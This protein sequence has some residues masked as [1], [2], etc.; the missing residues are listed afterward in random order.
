MSTA[1]A[2]YET[3]EELLQKH[4]DLLAEAASAAAQPGNNEEDVRVAAAGRL[5]AFIV[6]A[7]L[8]IKARHEYGLAGRRIDSKY[9]GV[10]IEY[11]NSNSSADRI[12]PAITAG[13]TQRLVRQI[14]GRFSDFESREGVPKDRIFAAGIDGRFILFVR[15]RNDKFEHDGPFEL[16]AATAERLLR[17]IVSLGANGEAF[18][19]V[20]LVR[21]FGSESK[22]A[23]AGIAALYEAVLSTTDA[24]AQMLF[25]EWKLLF[26]EV[27][28]YDVSGQ[29]KKVRKLADHYGITNARPAELL[30]AVH[31]YYSIFMKFMAAQIATGFESLATSIVRKC[32]QAPSMKALKREM[33]SLENGSLWAQLGVKNFLE[34][35]LFAWYLAAWDSSVS[36]V[37]AELATGL[38]RYD[39][40]TLSVDPENSR[41]LLKM[42]YEHL[43]PRS[44][45][46]DLGE[47]YT[48]DWLAEVV[49]DRVGY[50]GNPAMRV[51]DPACGSGT[52]L[53]AVLKRIRKWYADHRE[54]CGY[55]DRELISKILSNVIGFDLNPLAVMASKVNVLIAVR[56]LLKAAGEIEIPVYLCD[57]IVLPEDAGVSLFGTSWRIRTSVGIFSVPQ[58][59][60][61]E[62]RVLAKYAEI[63]EESVKG[64]YDATDFIERCESEGVPVTSQVEHLKLFAKCQK[65][66]SENKNGIWARIIKNAFAPLFL[67]P[68]DF[69]V[70]NPP[71]VNWEHMPDDYRENLKKT[72]E[73]YGLFTLSGTDARLGGGKKDL[74]MLFVYACVDR[75]LR[76]AGK[77]GFVIVQTVFK[78][79]GAGDGFRRFEYSSGPS[80]W[81]IQPIRVED[82]NRIQVFDNATNSAAVLVAEKTKKKVSYLIPYTIWNGPS[83][84]SQTA[85]LGEVMA[86][87]SQTEVRASPVGSPS[88]PW[89]TLP[90]EGLRIARHAVGQGPYIAQ[91]GATTWLNGVYWVKV[92]R[93]NGSM[94]LVENMN[95]V[96]KIRVR[97]QTIS[98]ES[99]RVVSLL[100]GRDVSSWLAMP[101]ASMLL[102]QDAQ[103]RTGISET[104]MK[105]KYPK[106]YAYLK[107]FEVRL[108]RRSGFKKYLKKQPFY[109]I[110][111]YGPQHLAP[112][113]VVWRDM[114]SVIQC[115]VLSSSS[116]VCPE[117][118]VMF[119]ATD[120]EDEAHYLCGAL[121]SSIAKLAVAGYTTITGISTHVLRVIGVPKYDGSTNHKAIAKRSREAH[122]A[123]RAGDEAG[124]AQAQAHLDQA[125]ETLWGCRPGDG[126]TARAIF[127]SFSA[128]LGITTTVDEADD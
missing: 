113:K 35:D 32:A 45:R 30:F 36:S 27:C 60:T 97:K 65:L 16:S 98:V 126:A 55:G 86:R 76:E 39:P 41:D 73:Y 38:D 70:G 26:S 7:G 20:N 120:S 42:L 77:L 33:E 100:R 57:S 101:S 2:N 3:T 111:N 127:E 93:R 29:H 95:D 83:R 89:L 116:P 122:M 123:K 69:V 49:L 121:M 12:R 103:T 8:D 17:A 104:I 64:Q 62:R 68:V 9:A 66:D 48:S 117:H 15:H 58:E 81:Y 124:V 25:G 18:L 118:H 115:A 75:F 54:S 63:L 71:W 31:T 119:V 21:D 105:R 44:V 1:K 84:I 91:A 102:T 110:F 19:P 53:V 13:S 47:Y 23:K 78:S 61:I 67:D 4:A 46:H 24:K 85:T 14:E 108:K 107:S 112:Y 96:G 128:R 82:L 99:S 5:D 72:W 6:D 90:D 87:T 92:L 10:I 34:G 37:I 11:K 80:R 79:Q 28:G 106:L 114:G 56:D 43:F 51:L 94:V 22:A 88:S 52:F 74:S 59:V 125:V 109:S 40:A 50:D